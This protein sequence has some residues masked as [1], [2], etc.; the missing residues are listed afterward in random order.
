M[1]LDFRLIFITLLLATRTLSQESWIVFPVQDVPVGSTIEKDLKQQMAQVTS[2]DNIASSTKALSDPPSVQFW[3]IYGT[4]AQADEIGGL[5]GVSPTERCWCLAKPRRS[6]LS[7]PTRSW[8]RTVV[9]T[10][11]LEISKQTVVRDFRYL[12]MTVDR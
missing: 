3:R 8:I 11:R 2:S 6:P 12:Y 7:L 9:S 5:N 10:A 1:P 4:K